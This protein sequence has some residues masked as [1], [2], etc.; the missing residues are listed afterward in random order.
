MTAALGYRSRSRGGGG[1]GLLFAIKNY[2]KAKIYGFGV[3]HTV[4]DLRNLE[5][6]TCSTATK[7]PCERSFLGRYGPWV[8]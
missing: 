2:S 7:F 6:F 5:V 1:R 8:G 4:S 3:H